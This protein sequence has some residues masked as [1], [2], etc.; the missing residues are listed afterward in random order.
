M[1]EQL[2]GSV[3][4]VKLFRLFFSNPDQPYFVRELTRKINQRINSV[5][6]ELNNL[7]EMGIVETR[8]SK[9]KKYY[10][11]KKDFPLYPELKSLMLKAQ[12]MLE[13]NFT[14]AI[15]QLGKIS[16]LV[17]TGQ[18]VGRKDIATDLLL[19]GQVNR[20][21]L[22]RLMKKFQEYFDHDINYTI[23]TVKEFEYRRQLT[24]R[25]LFQVLENKKIVVVD[26]LRKSKK[27]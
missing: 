24:D 17:L 16:F 14:R 9:R 19:V 15:S 11:L 21:K 1:L 6:Q 27:P 4:R 3:T 22:S 23:M 13:K 12:V 18:F 2:F 25:F 20:Q 5:R 8:E 7:E 26:K 10:T